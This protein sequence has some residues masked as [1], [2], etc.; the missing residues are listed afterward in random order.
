MPTNQHRE[1]PSPGVAAW[2]QFL[3]ETLVCL[4]LI[5]M[6]LAIALEARRSFL[7]GASILPLTA[8]VVGVARHRQ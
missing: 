8:F 4:V 2:R 3:L 1:G 6:I 7:A 5:V